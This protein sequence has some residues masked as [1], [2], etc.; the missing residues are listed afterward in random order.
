MPNYYDSKGNA[1]L[2]PFSQAWHKFEMDK[3][4]AVTQMQTNKW[5]YEQY[6]MQQ[7]RLARLIEEQNALLTLMKPD[8]TG[9]LIV[10]RLKGIN[11]KQSI[12]A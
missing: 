9:D 6:V 12:E 3:K 7:E 4:D 10:E 2:H 1:D 11:T 8:L 5:A